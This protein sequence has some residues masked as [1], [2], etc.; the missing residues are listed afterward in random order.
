ME[1][2]KDETPCS[3]IQTLALNPLFR[4]M[5][6]YLA[7]LLS[8]AR[9]TVSGGPIATLVSNDDSLLVQLPVELLLLAFP[10]P[11]GSSARS[12]T[13]TGARYS[14]TRGPCTASG[15]ASIPGW[16]T[17]FRTTWLARAAAGSTGSTCK[18]S[19]HAS[20]SRSKGPTLAKTVRAY[21]TQYTSHTS[22]TS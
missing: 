11:A 22:L 15:E 14:R 6:K 10:R 19:P 20:L 9:P 18:T 4:I 1:P 2:L 8:L 12:Y 7:S 17:T 5:F 21:N 3:Y 16:R 13:K